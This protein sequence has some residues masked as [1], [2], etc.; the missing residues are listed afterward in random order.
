MPR[1]DGAIVIFNLQDD[2]FDAEEVDFVEVVDEEKI[3]ARG[4]H[5]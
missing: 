3:V 1:V 4:V 2:A 5:H